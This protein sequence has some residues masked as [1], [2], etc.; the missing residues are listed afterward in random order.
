MVE[1]K[2]L[3]ENS[4]SFLERDKALSRVGNIKGFILDANLEGKV[5]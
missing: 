3:T 2:R 5:W 1:Y 4:T